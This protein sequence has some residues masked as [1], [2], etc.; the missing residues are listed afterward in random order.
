MAMNLRL[1]PEQTE[2]LKITAAQ[3]GISMQEAALQAIDAYI[4]ARSERL[5]AGMV[6]IARE[7]AELL[8]RCAQ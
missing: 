8:R 4:T 7:D 1:S 3:H 5:L 6:R 2:A